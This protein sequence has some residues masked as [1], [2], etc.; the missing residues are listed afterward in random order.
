ME[1]INTIV[2]G[3]DHAGFELK[4]ELKKYLTEAGYGVIDKGALQKDETDDYPDVVIPVAR[5]VA[6]D[7]EHCRG[8]IIGGSGQGEA[9]SANRIKNARAVVYYGGNTEIIKL[10]REHNN[11]NILSLGARFISTEEAKDTVTLWLNTPFSNE[12]RHI[13]RISKI[14]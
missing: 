2:I 7:P 10:S 4:E 1:N 5:Q 8:I 3:A 11:A 9:I 14:D 13:R 12:E 6:G